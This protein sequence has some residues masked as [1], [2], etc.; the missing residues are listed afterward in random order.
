M[1]T[2]DQGF[3]VGNGTDSAAPNHRFSV[4]VPTYNRAGFILE[5]LDTVKAQTYRP[6]EIIVVDDGSTD[7][8]GEV[9]SGWAAANEE[10]QTLEVRYFSQNNAGPAA[11]RNR[12][13]RE[14]KGKY[15]QFLDSDDRLHPERL[16]RLVETFESSGADFIQTGFESID[17]DTG[18]T[19]SQHFGKPNHHQVELA[20]HGRLWANTLRSAFR[21]SLVETIGPWDEEMT[22]FEDRDYVERAVCRA[23]NP[24]A[25]R[26]ILASARRGGSERISDRLKTYE[27]RKC[28]ILCERRLAKATLG[29]EDISDV[30]R[31]AFASRL[32]GLGFRS[33]ASGWP[34]LGSECGEIAASVNDNLDLKGRIRKL[35]WKN[36]RVGGLVYGSLGRV[37]RF[38][39]GVRR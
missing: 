39:G 13:I 24:V 31:Q 23:D 9:V 37:K 26:E 20:L 19:I 10:P 8:T 11:A 25:V 27:G 34:D 1:I 12:G 32:Y 38:V 6:C 14:I 18:E 22:C 15:V 21:R 28:R 5:A 2:H 30:A 36:G 7:G 3:A 4:I 29:R 35:V 33:N 17:A 16:A